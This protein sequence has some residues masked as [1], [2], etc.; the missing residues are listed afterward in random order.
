V[1]DQRIPDQESSTSCEAWLEQSP[2]S[3]QLRAPPQRRRR[4]TA[5]GQQ[6]QLIESIVANR[7]IPRLLLTNATDVIV[8][9]SE[10]ATQPAQ[11]RSSPVANASLTGNV[12]DFSEL[13]IAQDA[14]AC[15]TYFEAR[16]AQ[17]A[18]IEALFQDL[19][20]PTARRLGV[21]WEEDINDFVDVTRG[22]TH[23]QQIV[24]D[25][26]DEFRKEGRVPASHRRALVM[27]VPGEQH[28]F[29]ATL[30]AE[31]FRREG[32]RVWGGPAQHIDDILELVD[33]QHF[34]VVG[35]SVGRLDDTQTVAG[36]IRRVRAA[37]L[38]KNVAILVGGKAFLDR[39]DL[40]SA[41]GA[42]ATA[43]D[44]Q[45]AVITAGKLLSPTR[46]LGI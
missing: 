20:A 15:L 4:E 19:L 8:T 9:A 21:L 31:Q 16:R 42:H 17:G 5:D 11:A 2:F 43:R 30:I 45:D 24:H 7:I 34:D 36:A 1:S 25:Y 10:V 23:L 40:V 18:S 35:L 22:F 6:Q 26:S 29:G 39:P 33:A 38:N 44:A 46:R 41:V 28:T 3:G 12:G 27:P 13:V 32:W 14:H 37:S